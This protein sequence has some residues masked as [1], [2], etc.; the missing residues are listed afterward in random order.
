[1]EEYELNGH[2][3]VFYEDTHT[4]LVDN[5]K[6]PSVTGIL[7]ETVFK[8]KYKGIDEKT[9]EKASIKGTNMHKTIE[10][11]EKEGKELKLIMYD[12]YGNEESNSL[13]ELK[14]YKTLK[15]LYGFDVEHSEIPIIIEIDGKVVCA[16]KLDQ[17]I[18]LPIEDNKF[19]K[20]VN[21]LK[22]TAT[23]DLEYLAYQETIYAIGYE[24]C[25]GEKIDELRGTHLRDD[26]KQF[27]KVKRIDDIVLKLLKDYVKEHNFEKFL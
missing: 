20:C 7:H 5:V 10:V 21:D 25:Y 27:K 8:D 6:V 17:I 19:I 1:M 3:L 12:K 15:R 18:D 14:G 22:R 13:R 9:L 23:L 11:Y 16:G 24:Q 26:K 2:K 4:Y